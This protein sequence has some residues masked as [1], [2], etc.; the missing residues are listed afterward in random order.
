MSRAF[1]LPTIMFFRIKGEEAYNTSEFSKK[2]AEY[3]DIKAGIQAKKV[4]IFVI[5]LVF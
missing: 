1:F 4:L 5:G 2:P 3:Q